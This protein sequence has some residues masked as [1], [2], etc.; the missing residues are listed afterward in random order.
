MSVYTTYALNA[1][2]SICMHTLQQPGLK[3]LFQPYLQLLTHTWP[4]PQ[5]IGTL[6][7]PERSLY[8]SILLWWWPVLKRNPLLTLSSPISLWQSASHLSRPLWDVPPQVIEGHSKKMCA[9]LCVFKKQGEK[10]ITLLLRSQIVSV[11]WISFVFICSKI[12]VLTV[13]YLTKLPGR[14]NE[15]MY[16]KVFSKWLSGAKH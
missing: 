3:L 9:S 15:I 13:P 10:H 14:S 5:I 11:L 8:F 16:G 12:V 4:A 6:L 1:D 2:P 7:F